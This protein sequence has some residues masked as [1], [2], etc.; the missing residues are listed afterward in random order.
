MR[1]RR[2]LLATFA[3]VIGVVAACDDDTTAPIP[4]FRSTLSPASET[5][6]VTST[7]TGSATYTIEGNTLHYTVSVADLTTT[8][9]AAHIHLGPVGV[10]GPIIF[11]FFPAGTTIP[12]ALTN[13]SFASGTIDLTSANISN[14]PNVTISG[15]SLRKL[16][17]TAQIYTNVHT[18]RFPGGEIRGQ[19]LVQ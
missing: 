5:S 12:T 3:L 10:A 19:I 16:L 14:R 11:D 15:D 2:L 8:P 4:T 18:S 1:T 7:A 6:P 9:V 17:N 13:A